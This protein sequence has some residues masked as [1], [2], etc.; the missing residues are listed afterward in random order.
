MSVVSWFAYISIP[1][2]DPVIK[3]GMDTIN[4][5]NPPQFM[6]VP[7]HDLD[8]QSHMARSFLSSLS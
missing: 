5:L 7:S 1:V 8:F 3:R 4:R 2:G 6:S